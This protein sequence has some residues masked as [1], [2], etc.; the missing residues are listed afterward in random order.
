MRCDTFPVAIAVTPS[1]HSPKLVMHVQ[2]VQHFPYS[3]HLFEGTAIVGWELLVIS[4]VYHLKTTCHSINKTCFSY[5]VNKGLSFTV[6][7]DFSL[8]MYLFSVTR[9]ATSL[10][11]VVYVYILKNVQST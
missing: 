7:F 3:F 10:I 1:R 5:N 9:C 6:V 8:K 2:P 11:L 4:S